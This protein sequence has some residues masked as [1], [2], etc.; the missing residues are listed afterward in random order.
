MLVA[1]MAGTSNAGIIRVTFIL[2][3][4]K[5]PNSIPENG[6]HRY[7]LF[8]L[9]SHHFGLIHLCAVE[10]LDALAS[11]VLAD[12]PN[13][14]AKVAEIERLTNLVSRRLPLGSLATIGHAHLLGPMLSG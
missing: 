1:R 3:S 5:V 2:L 12:D 4:S 8:I 14:Q 10:S 7:G 13:A 6:S 9:K 11:M